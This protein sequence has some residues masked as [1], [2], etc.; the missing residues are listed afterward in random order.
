MMG[1]MPGSFGVA[2]LLATFAGWVNR[3]QA[4]AIDYL[5]EENRVLKEQLRG[6][7]LSAER[8]S[9]PTARGQGQDAGAQ[10]ARSAR[11]PAAAHPAIRTARTHR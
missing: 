11:Q 5:I 4:E 8:R 10:V 3:Q 7:P 9:T 1:Q 6:K 2:F